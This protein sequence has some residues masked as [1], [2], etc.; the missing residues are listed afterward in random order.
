MKAATITFA[1]MEARVREPLDSASRMRSLLAMLMDLPRLLVGSSGSTILKR[2][3]KAFVTG[4]A[5]RGGLHISIHTITQ[6]HSLMTMLTIA[7]AVGGQQRVHDVD[8]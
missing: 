7:Q 4:P 8:A 2:L 6:K 3:M 5:S 1:K